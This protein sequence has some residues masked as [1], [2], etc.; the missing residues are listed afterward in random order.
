ML[1]ENVSKWPVLESLFRLTENSMELN[2]SIESFCRRLVFTFSWYLKDL[3]EQITFVLKALLSIRGNVEVITTICACTIEFNFLVRLT[4]TYLANIFKLRASDLVV[5]AIA[6]IPCCIQVVMLIALIDVRLASCD[7][8]FILSW[9]HFA[10]LAEPFIIEVLH[11]IA[12][13]LNAFKLVFRG[14]KILWALAAWAILIELL[15]FR[16]SV[17]H[18]NRTIVGWPI[19]Q[20]ITV[21][22]ETKGI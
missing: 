10:G 17:W 19:H 7:I 21:S 9:I 4:F 6:A 14:M 11:R 8:A 18:A 16:A 20:G 22:T 13:I 1:D 15:S 12:D 3:R 5:R 2:L